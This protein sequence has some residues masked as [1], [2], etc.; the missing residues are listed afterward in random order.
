[1]TIIPDV[2]QQEGSTLLY[3]SDLLQESG[4]YEL[5]KQDS[6]LS[7]LAFNDNRKE[8]DMSYLTADNLKQ[9][10]PQAGNVLQP[11]QASIKAEVSDLNFG[12]QLWKLCII[13][14]LIFLATEILFIRYYKL[15]K[16]QFS[17][18]G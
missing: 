14:A 4:N 3:A 8:S 7:V 1:M 16:Q 2:K 5:K 6:I 9:I 17:E 18:L 13:L 10:F 11:G 15:G 12:L